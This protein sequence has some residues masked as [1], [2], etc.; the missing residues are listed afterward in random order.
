MSKL[1]QEVFCKKRVLKSFAKIHRKTPV[2]QS[3]CEHQN[4]HHG[5][6]IGKCV[7]LKAGLSASNNTLRVLSLFFNPFN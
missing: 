2:P 6:F 5:D 7:Y 1:F 3:L 4:T